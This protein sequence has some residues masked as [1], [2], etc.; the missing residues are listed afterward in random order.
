MNQQ[1]QNANEKHSQDR[2][3]FNEILTQSVEKIG[4]LE[5]IESALSG[6]K[7]FELHNFTGEVMDI[8]RLKSKCKLVG[9]KKA[10]DNEDREIFAT[11]WYIWGGQ[12]QEK[13]GEL[14][15]STRL[16][17]LDDAGEVLVTGSQYAIKDFIGVISELGLGKFPEPV[18]L[19]LVGVDAKKGTCH[20]L[21]VV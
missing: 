2:E 10:E 13:D 21:I 5:T 7:Y 9:N 3:V 16:A 11:Q 6:G 14:K 8:L 15:M 1:Q 18:L 20:R 17:L 4:L 19:K 12:T